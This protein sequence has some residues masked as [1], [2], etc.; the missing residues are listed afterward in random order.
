[1]AFGM[2]V[3][4]YA[5]LRAPWYKIAFNA[6][7]KGM[8]VGAA[9][10]VWWQVDPHYNHLWSTT[11]PNDPSWQPGE[12]RDAGWQVN[13]KTRPVL[14]DALHDLSLH[15]LPPEGVGMSPRAWGWTAGECLPH[16]GPGNVPTCVGVDRHHSAP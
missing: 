12:G 5:L 7:Q 14:R 15:R 8:A 6:S 9:S 3:I 4:G 1:M 13:Y 2:A 10:L 16:R 11:C